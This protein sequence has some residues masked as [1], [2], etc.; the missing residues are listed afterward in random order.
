MIVV[1]HTRHPM[2]VEVAT[3]AAE[4]LEAE[5]QEI[6]ETDGF[7][8]TVRLLRDGRP[9]AAVMWHSD[10]PRDLT[11]VWTRLVDSA[12][13]EGLTV[14]EGLERMKRRLGYQMGQRGRWTKSTGSL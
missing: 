3:Q 10:R 13:T 9:I 7:D 14:P 11:E 2:A 6:D 12:L 4:R 1:L 8:C 5:L